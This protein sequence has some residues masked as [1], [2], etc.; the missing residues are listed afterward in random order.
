M[1]DGVTSR[2]ARRVC[3]R[4][5][6]VPPVVIR[7]AAE[8]HPTVR[9]TAVPPR[10]RAQQRRSVSHLGTD[11]SVTNEPETDSGPAVGAGSAAGPT[12]RR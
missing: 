2:R 9:S 4:V 10:R 3:F 11:L 6:G 5:L 1:A 8:R 7:G 12:T